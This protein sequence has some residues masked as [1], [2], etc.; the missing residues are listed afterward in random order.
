MAKRKTEM[1]F[2]TAAMPAV[3]RAALVSE[4]KALAFTQPDLQYHLLRLARIGGLVEVEQEIR[5]LRGYAKR[6]NG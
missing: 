2:S 3:E 4:M 5:K 6:A 1:E